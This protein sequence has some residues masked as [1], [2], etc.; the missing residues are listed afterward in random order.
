[1]LGVAELPGGPVVKHPPASAGDM[2]SISGPGRSHRLQ[3][4]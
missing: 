3:G 1:M 2:D 4:S